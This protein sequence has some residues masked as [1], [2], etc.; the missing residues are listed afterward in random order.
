MTEPT[1]RDP[2][3]P[4]VPNIFRKCPELPPWLARRVLQRDEQITWIRGPERSPPWECC[5]T[6]P[7]AGFAAMAFGVI[8]SVSGCVWT[9]SWSGLVSLPVLFTWSLF[10]VYIIVLGISAGYFTRLIVTNQR[11]VLIQGF[12]IIRSWSLDQLPRSLVR[13]S[14]NQQ[15]QESRT[16]DL[17]GLQSLLGGVSDQFA[18]AKTLKAF[19]KQLDRIKARENDHP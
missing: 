10:V 11:V 19:S 18:D 5:V 4:T 1:P 15:G 17:Q 16:V 12:E 3:D 6:H 7:L 14:R 9:E 2:L 13:F 8:V